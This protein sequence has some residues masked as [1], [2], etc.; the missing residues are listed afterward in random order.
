MKYIL[1]FLF[2]FTFTIFGQSAANCKLPQK[3]YLTID[4][5][6]NCYDVVETYDMIAKTAN[7]NQ[8]IAKE[9]F[10]DELSTLKNNLFILLLIKKDTDKKLVLITKTT[11]NVITL[12]KTEIVPDNL[13]TEFNHTIKLEGDKFFIIH[14]RKNPK[15]IK[16]VDDVVVYFD[17]TPLTKNDKNEY[18]WADCKIGEKTTISLEDFSTSKDMID[19]FCDEK[20]IEEP[21][22]KVTFKSKNFY[23]L[24]DIANVIG[25]LTKKHEGF[26]FSVVNNELIAKRKQNA[27]ICFYFDNICLK[28]RILTINPKVDDLNADQAVVD[29]IKSE[30]Q[31]NKPLCFDLE[32]NVEQIKYSI[33]DLNS[34]PKD[35]TITPEIVKDGFKEIIIN[36]TCE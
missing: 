12:R 7:G 29:V 34:E 6:A 4:K 14:S 28:N 16:S 2:L 9:S 19:I 3:I 11:S 18:E 31:I 25:Y 17:K 33:S 30:I 5:K 24:K 20:T 35:L 1:I 22:G 21:I 13:L 32:N 36:D 26:E 27:K 8:Q 23:Y 15:I 10:P